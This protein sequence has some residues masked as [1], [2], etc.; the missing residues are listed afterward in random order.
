MKIVLFGCGQGGW[1]AAKWLLAGTKLLAIADN[2][3]KKWGTSLEGI[4]VIEPAKILTLSPDMVFITILNKDAVDTIKKQL[5]DMGYTGTIQTLNPFREIMDLRL[6]HLR[7]LAREIEARKLPGAI[8]ELG[9]YQ[10]VFAAELNRLF[11]DRT[12]YLFDTFQ[13]FAEED[14]AIEKQLTAYTRAA[15]GDFKDTSIEQVRSRL[16]H[17]ERAVFLP[18]HF[19]DTLPE[20]LPPLAFVS[21][22]PDLYE[23]TLAGLRAF[24]PKLVPGGVILIHDYNSAQ[25]EG[26]GK[27]VRMFCEEQH[28]MIL[29]LADL[30]GSA[31]LMRQG[32]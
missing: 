7:L 28:L 12:L 25:F 29:P 18:G 3:P 5:V 6:A 32:A 30:H 19:P 9:V 27:A 20:D 24:W 13:G 15:A 22:D 17:P 23:P 4:P 16:P 31:V 21:L 14:V 1:M 26:A 10:G 2:N 11:P 8:A